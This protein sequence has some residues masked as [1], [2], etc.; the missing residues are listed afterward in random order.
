MSMLSTT[1]TWRQT[2]R[3]SALVAQRHWT[4][5]KRNF[6][7]NISPT[8]VDPTLYVIVFGSWLGSQVQTTGERSYL[9]FMAPGISAMTA[10]FTSFFEGSYGFYVRLTYE[11]IYKALM[12]TPVGPREILLGELMWLGLKSAIMAT[13]VSLVLIALGICKAHYVY[14]TPLM[15]FFIGTT[16][17]SIGLISCTYVKN[18]NQ[19]QS[20]YAW[21]ISPMFFV[22]GMFVPTSVMPGIVK[23]ILWFSPFYHGVQLAQGILW[24]ENIIYVLLVHGGAL[25]G[26]SVVLTFWMWRRIYPKLYF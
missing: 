4:I 2:F 17:G 15:G 14:L 1:G 9:E 21:I 23:N 7:A 8:L 24:A 5:Y 10:F 3:L 16:C 6:F 12:T 11:N 20:V 19:F 22:S 18:I 26:M 13:A 25:L